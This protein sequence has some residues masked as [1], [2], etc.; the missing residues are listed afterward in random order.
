MNC[1]EARPLLLAGDHSA[2]AHL[3]GCAA[4]GAWLDTHDPIVVRFLAARPEAL[5]APASLRSG[6]LRRFAPGRR[7]WA[8]PATLAAATLVLVG[9]AVYALVTLESGPIAAL[10]GYAQP[11]IGVFAGPRELLLGNLAGLLGLSGLA[12]L[13][14]GL[15]GFVYRDLGRRTRSLAR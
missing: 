3:E 7:S 12:L 5:P 14:V 4:C 2:E 11:V 15:A 10:A 6:V 8:L 1:A 13:T 9:A